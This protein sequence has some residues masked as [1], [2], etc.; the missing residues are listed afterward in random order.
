MLGA[1]SSASW[2]CW[3]VQPYSMTC[4]GISFANPCLFIGRESGWRATKKGGINPALFHAVRD[5]LASILPVSLVSRQT[6][7]Q[8]GFE[9]RMTSESSSASKKGGSF[10]PPFVGRGESDR[11]HFLPQQSLEVQ[12]ASSFATFHIELGVFPG[13]LTI[14]VFGFG[15]CRVVPRQFWPWGNNRNSCSRSC[16]TQRAGR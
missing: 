8:A 11:Y 7:S 6:R 13:R 14:F 9:A 16:A 1:A 4:C 2:G 12:D 3:L 5:E 10:E 15:G